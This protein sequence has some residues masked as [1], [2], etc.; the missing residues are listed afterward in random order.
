MGFTFALVFALAVILYLFSGWVER[1]VLLHQPV[2]VAPSEVGAGAAVRRVGPRSFHAEDGRWLEVG[3]DPR[4]AAVVAV[5]DGVVRQLLVFE[6][7]LEPLLDEGVPVVLAM[8][9]PAG[10][11]GRVLEILPTPPE[12]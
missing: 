5:D 3:V 10:G 4:G 6:P 7:E 12:P 11:P 9:D 1:Q 2:L 8:E